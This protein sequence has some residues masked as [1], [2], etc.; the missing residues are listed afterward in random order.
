MT[1][2]PDIRPDIRGALLDRLAALSA[3][4]DQV[5]R[6]LSQPHDPD[7][8]EQ[9]AEREGEEAEAALGEA[10]LSEITAIRA[11]IARIDE[12]SYGRCVTCDGEIS[13][14]RL[15][16]IPAASQCFDCASANPA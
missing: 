14:Q 13:P 2:G 11:A 5:E 15:V 16:A 1:T 3:R 8:S 10:T 12:G 6:D 4:L 9:A 7:S